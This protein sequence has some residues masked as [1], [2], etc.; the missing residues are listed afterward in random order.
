MQADSM[1]KVNIT[2]STSTKSR[3][4]LNIIIQITQH[5]NNLLLLEK[6][7]TFLNMGKIYLRKNKDAAD[8]KITNLKHANSFINKFE[9]VVHNLLGVKALDYLDFCKIINLMNEKM[10][11]TQEGLDKIKEI[12]SNVNNQRK[13]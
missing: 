2:N 9:S 13:F 7:Q 6:I 3:Y 12:N 1:F 4:Q 11:L 5:S 8:L 10:H